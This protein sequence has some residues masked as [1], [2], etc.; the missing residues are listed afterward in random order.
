[1]QSHLRRQFGMLFRVDDCERVRDGACR[2]N[3]PRLLE[4][5]LRRNPAV[6]AHDGRTADR[7]IADSQNAFNADYAEGE[8]SLCRCR[9]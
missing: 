4:G 2:H 1:M 8:P 5:R 6:C 9:H 3:S 7:A